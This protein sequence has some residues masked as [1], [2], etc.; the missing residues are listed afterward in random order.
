M[1][2]ISRCFATG[3]WHP[4][5]LIPGHQPRCLPG[6]ARHRIQAPHSG[7]GVSAG[8]GFCGK[9][10]EGTLSCPLPSCA[11][12]M[13]ARTEGGAI[14][15]FRLSG[16]PVVRRPSYLTS[17]PSRHSGCQYP[18]YPACPVCPVVR[19]P[20]CPGCPGCPADQLSDC[21]TVRRLGIPVVKRSGC[22]AVQ[23]SGCPTSRHSGCSTFRLPGC[24]A[25]RRPS[26]RNPPAG[27][28]LPYSSDCETR[29]S[30]PEVSFTTM[31][32]SSLVKWK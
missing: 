11:S 12:P 14:A 28:G 13:P 31:L 6:L 8:G 26:V 4:T 16:H 7:I 9:N 24:P 5:Q 20:G 30:S 29:K 1:T 27:Q 17:R 19:R 3:K 21:P 23:L 2:F 15:A 25:V 32:P 18:G 22:P 10:K